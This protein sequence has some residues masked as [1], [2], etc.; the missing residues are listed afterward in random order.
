MIEIYKK[1]PKTNCGRCGA[2]TCMAFAAMVK[3]AQA[4]LPDCPFM[5]A[6]STP[7]AGPKDAGASPFS[8]YEQVSDELEKEATALDFAETAP[9]LG[10]T[11]VSPGGREA[12]VLRMM[13]KTYE[14]RKEGLFENN[15]RCEDPWTKIIMYDY[16]RRKGRGNL[17]GEWINLGHFPDTASHVK[18][19]QA[20]ADRKVAESFKNDV[21]GLARRSRELGG[22]KAEGRIKADCTYRF[23]LLPHV[24]L[25]LLFWAADDEFGAECRL[26][27]DSS[28]E[29][30]IDI[31][32]LAYL[33]ERFVAELTGAR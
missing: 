23:D 14:L 16:V 33:L 20:D 3:K 4:V 7:E 26:L 31:E 28:A 6:D 19:F 12:I 22:I 9:V 2:A 32:Y 24:P 30:F 15:S 25:Y 29:G 5:G 1:L 13:N 11:Y 21:E 27:F 10:G 17:T 18:A 8:T